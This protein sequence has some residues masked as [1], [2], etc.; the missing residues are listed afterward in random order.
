MWNSWLFILIKFIFPC[1]FDEKSVLVWNLQQ[2]FL[3]QSLIGKDSVSHFFKQMMFTY[4]QKM[5]AKLSLLCFV[6]VFK[7]LCSSEL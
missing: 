4:E 3:C 2:I 7:I 6:S 5:F 1:N